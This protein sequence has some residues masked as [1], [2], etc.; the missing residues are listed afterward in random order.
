MSLPTPYYDAAGITIFHGDCREI[1][2]DVEG[3]TRLITDPV[4]PNADRRLA[5]AD[6]PLRLLREALALSDARTV[7]LQLGRCS[8]PRILTAVSP[9]LPFIAVCSLRYVP[10]SYRGRVMMESDIAYAFGETIRSVP[11]RRVIPFTVTSTRGEFPRGTGRNRSSAEFQA[12]QDRMPHPAPRHLK[13]VTWLV[14]WFSDTGDV[15]LDP[16]AG[17]GTTLV[18]AKNLGRRSIGIEIEERYC[19]IAAERLRQAVFDFQPRRHESDPREMFND[20]A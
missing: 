7:V 12:A 17:T 10:P 4:W 6:N 2:P 3:A 19:D 15:V 9:D 20:G 13:H 18:A 16:F 8:D 14:N 1:L 5:G 11:G